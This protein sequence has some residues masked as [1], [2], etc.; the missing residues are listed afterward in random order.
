[1]LNCQQTTLMPL[2]RP[3]YKVVE[4]LRPFL[5]IEI[6]AITEISTNSLIFLRVPRL[7]PVEEEDAQRQERPLGEGAHSYH[8]I[9]SRQ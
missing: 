4:Q 5:Q 9:T 8:E 3:L 2:T 1:M 6:N 7:H